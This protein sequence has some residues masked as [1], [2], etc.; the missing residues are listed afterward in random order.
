[1]PDASFLNM[2]RRAHPKARAEPTTDH[3]TESSMGI[4][5]TTGKPFLELDAALD[6]CIEIIGKT[7]G[8][9]EAVQALEVLR[10]LREKVR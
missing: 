10:E 6:E 9:E 8:S 7:Y 5:I 2:L 1:M 4:D 3:E